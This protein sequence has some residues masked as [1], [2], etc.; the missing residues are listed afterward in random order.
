MKSRLSKKLLAMAGAFAVA[1]VIGLGVLMYQYRNPARPDFLKVEGPNGYELLLEAAGK[2][3][4]D[5][6]EVTN[7]FGAFVEAH[8]GM[9]ADLAEGLKHPAEAPERAYEPGSMIYKELIPLRKL[10]N[11]LVVKANLA[12]EES[13]WGDAAEVYLEGIRLGQKLE[14][15]PLIYLMLGSAIELMNV[16]K[17]SKI[18]P[19]LNA[20]ELGRFAGEVSKMNEER[21]LFGEV[22]RRERYFVQLNAKNLFEHLRYRFLGKLKEVFEGAE[23]RY[24]NTAAQMEILAATMAALKHTMEEKKWPERLEEVGGTGFVDPY[25]GEALRYLV[26]ETN[27]VIYSAGPNRED[28]GGQKD[29]VTLEHEDS[30]VWKM[31]AEALSN[32]L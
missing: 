10:G 22:C 30:V 12:R 29:D 18:V 9:F 20:E 25:T 3:Q 7:N 24:L 16:E 1:V 23:E 5:P 27:F 31:M 15:G 32:A 21:V 19:R 4:V 17:L 11:A 26:R 6:R 2:L 28:D 8:E 13:R 14:H